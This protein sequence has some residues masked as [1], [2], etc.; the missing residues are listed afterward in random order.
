MNT[1]IF[2]LFLLL[3]T[4]LLRFSVGPFPTTILEILTLLTFATFVFQY[5]KSFRFSQIPNFLSKNKLIAIG[6]F[7]FLLGSTISI[8]T[9]VDVRKALGEWKAFYV[10][11][12][13]LFLV[14]S[15]HLKSVGAKRK[16]IIEKY[17]LLPLLLCGLG[18][19]LLAIYQHFTGWMVPEAFWANRN[20]F[21]VTGWYGFPNAVGLFLA[22]L[23]PLSLFAILS[24][25]HQ[26]ISLLKMTGILTF[27][28]IPFA[29][30]F[31]KGSGPIIGML[32]GIGFLLLIYKKTRSAAIIAGIV[33]LVSLFVLPIPQSVKDELFFQDRSGQIRL[34]IW[35]ET[36]KFLQDSPVLGAGIAS[37]DEKIAPYHQLVNG[38]GIEIFHH[39]HNIFLTMW[40]N[41]GLVGL[42]GFIL[43][44]I[45]FFRMG[46]KE[47]KKNPLA[48]FVLATMVT[49]LIMGLVDSPYIK[50][51]LSIFFWLLPALLF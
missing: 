4:Y 3:P 41:L 33:G 7:L 26:K 48:P 38:E 24:Q 13:L 5:R 12:V 29:L 35:Q 51:D 6:V 46:F 25:R 30:I 19:A 16:E 14:I 39:P 1:L 44:L 22:P 18:T 21:R 11:P 27:L 36:K 31:A 45:S 47:L 42:M 28:T 34:S 8:F 40:V 15:S 10:E 20:T 32:A 37:Y 9:A 50:N 17:I 49:I 43:I 23:I 2:I